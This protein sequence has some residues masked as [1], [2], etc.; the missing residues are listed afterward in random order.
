MKQGKLF[1]NVEDFINW[2]F[3]VCSSSHWHHTGII[4][5]KRLFKF[6]FKSLF[7][8]VP[9]THISKRWKVNY[10]QVTWN[11]G[12]FL[13]ISTEL[14]LS[15]ILINSPKC[16][17]IY[18]S[19]TTHI[20]IWCSSRQYILKIKVKQLICSFIQFESSPTHGNDRITTNHTTA[21]D[22]IGEVMVLSEDEWQKQKKLDQKKR[23]GIVLWWRPITTLTYFF[24]ELGI[25]LHDYK[26]R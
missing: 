18:D 26:E 10:S 4:I 25:L 9:C 14:Y 7:H 12:S 6:F 3:Y 17:V 22:D 2:N 15:L 16:L 1:N 13:P 5:F 21:G 11:W 8:P 24:F 23:H 19:K 20:D